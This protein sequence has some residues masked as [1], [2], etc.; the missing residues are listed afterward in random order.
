MKNKIYSMMMLA[1]MLGFSSCSKDDEMEI[2]ANTIEYDGTKSVL[3]KGALIDFDISPYYG[4]TDTHL[5]YDFYITDGAVITDNTGQIF[6]IQ[7]KFGVWI[8]L[9]SFG[10]TGGF[11]TGTYT[12]IDGVND[13][14][15]TDAQKKT[16]YE[17]K[18]FMAGASVFLN[19]NVST[20]FDSGNTQEIE[21]KSGSVTVSGSK[22]NY[23][24]TYDLVMENNKT[25]KGSYS[26]GF[27]AF[28]D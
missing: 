21:I 12:F 19:T 28:V 26:A 11:K 5:N 27:Q 6:D 17:N 25:V 10:T 20:S 16:K 24:I 2:D 1:L 9:E 15:L 8:W 13:A 18:L 3:K 4:T 14:S 7:G 23:T 22:P